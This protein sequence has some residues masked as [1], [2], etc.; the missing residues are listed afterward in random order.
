MEL[1][2]DTL[3]DVTQT[4]KDK[5][6]NVFSLV[7]FVFECWGRVFEKF[8]QLRKLVGPCQGTYMVEQLDIVM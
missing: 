3:R 2:V 6:L 4:Q 7:D 5:T 1:E 8:L